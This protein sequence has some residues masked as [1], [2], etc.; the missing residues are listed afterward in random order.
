MHD[1]IIRNAKIYDGSGAPWF[2]GDLGVNDDKIA[3]V[4]TLTEERAQVDID[5]EG[6]V[7]SPGFIDM[8]THSDLQPLGNPLHTCKTQQGVTTDV[9]GHDGLGLAPVTPD[10]AAML[11]AQL[12][13]WNGRPDVDWDWSTVTT[14]LDRF[15]RQVAVNVAML[16]PHGTVRMAVMGMD[17]RAPSPA[18]LAQMQRLVVQCMQEGAIGLSTG[19]TYAPCSFATDDELVELCKVLRP[20]GG[21][22]CPHHRNYGM[23]ALEAYIDSIEIARRA[24]VPI[25]LTHCHFG[26]PVNHGRADELLAVFDQA[27]ADGIEVTLDTYPYIAGST[28]LHSVLPAWMNDGGSQAIMARL[29]DPEILPG[30]RHELEVAGSDGFHGVPLGWE[31]IQIAGISDGSRPELIGLRMDEA[32]A[33]TSQSTFDF[34]VDL[35]VQTDLGVTIL[36]FIGN[37]ENVQR[38]L[39]HP[40]HVVGSDGIIVGARPHPRGWGSHVRFLAHYV[41]VLGLL[42]WE[43]GIRHMTSAPARR[44]G[45][46][47]R[48]MIRPGLKA[49]LVL[50]DPDK[51]ADTATYEEPTRKPEGIHH[52]WVNGTSVVL[53]GNPTGE[54]PG[55]ALRSPNGRTPK[56]ITDLQLT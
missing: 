7:L 9:I 6:R 5:A 45:A 51:L 11:A 27:I 1:L 40:A 43:E 10:T 29:Q 54:T 25:H 8:H 49:D 53:D 20:F 4:G 39:Q 26:F 31:M 22:Y 32:A 52:V 34:F 30:L 55:R 33:R 3:A 2:W 36:A 12:A 13:G 44:I 24:G 16:V 19:L 46:L 56:R 42:T 41:R 47:D 50:F 28:Y 21:F 35:L 48:G 37:E 17:N 38:I 23:T 14:Y 18:E 15:D